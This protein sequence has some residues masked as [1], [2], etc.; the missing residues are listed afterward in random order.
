MK[1]KKIIDRVEEFLKINRGK[2][3]SIRKIH[4]AIRASYPAVQRAVAVLEAKGKIK[5]EDLGN[6]KLIWI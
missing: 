3:F 1:K 2:R 4:Q 6:T 5:I